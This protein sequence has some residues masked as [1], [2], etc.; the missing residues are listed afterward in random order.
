MSHILYKNGT[1]NKL[2]ETRIKTF[3]TN[4]SVLTTECVSFRRI[5]I[6]S[7]LH[8]YSSI[9]EPLMAYHTVSHGGSIGFVCPKIHFIDIS[10]ECQSAVSIK[11][12]SLLLIS[13]MTNFCQEWMNEIVGHTHTHT[14]LVH[15][16]LPTNLYL[17]FSS[18][19]QETLSE[20]NSIPL[21]WGQSLLKW[22][23]LAKV[24]RETQ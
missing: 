3:Q 15:F 6:Q 11:P 8:M 12:N 22:P 9:P 1:L 4:V 7:S 10:G 23:H 2:F 24:H 20:F 13:C 16:S 21:M 14:A 18:H 19:N 5:P 17:P